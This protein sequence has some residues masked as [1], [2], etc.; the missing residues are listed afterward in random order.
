MLLAGYDVLHKN[1]LARDQ[2]YPFP[3]A[4]H[5]KSWQQLNSQLKRTLVAEAQKHH[6]CRWPSIPAAKYMDFT[7]KG[8]RRGFEELYFQRRHMLAI[9]V[10]GECIEHQGR[11]LDDII[12]GV[13]LICEETSWILPAHNANIE[14]P[15]RDH[16]DI[17][18]FAAETG[19]LLS[20]VFYLLGDELDQRSPMVRQRMSKEII[21]RVIDPF[22][23]TNDFHWLGFNLGP[24]SSLHNWTT[25]I[26]SNIITAL[27]LV[28]EDA[29]KRLSGIEKIVRSIDIFLE[30][31]HTDGGCDEG[32]DYWNRAGGSLF[33]LLEQLYLATQSQFTV[34]DQP[35]IGRIGAYIYRVNIAGDYFVNFADA[36]AK[37]TING[38]TAYLYG[39]R[40]KDKRL[41]SLGALVHQRLGITGMI[42]A[43]ILSLF[44][45]LVCIFNHDEITAYIP[46]FPYE[47]DVWLH[48][49]Q[50]VAAREQPNST[51][52]L[53]FA[54]KGGHNDESHNHN[55]VG[56]FILFYNGEPVFIDVGVETYTAKTF[57][58][59]RYCIWTMQSA[60]HNLPLIGKYQQQAGRRYT[61]SQVEYSSKADYVRFA[62][63]IA[64][65][66]SQAAGIIIWKRSY[67]LNRADSYFEITDEFK[68]RAPETVAVVFISSE[69]MQKTKSGQII[70]ARK[71]NSVKLSYDS[72]V[73]TFQSEKIDICDQ[74]LSPVWGKT[75]YRNLLLTKHVVNQEKWIFKIDKT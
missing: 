56:S 41:A 6:C 23:A 13:W 55:D 1:I 26:N 32:P 49:T 29:A 54:A 33:D 62:M 2:F 19:A 5:R 61:A 59:D 65:A 21:S 51:A 7:R 25:W 72:N 50:I 36:S 67:L 45:V 30:R 15:D 24:D 71:H 60:Y 58:K 57:G 34:Y 69:E 39:K 12:N 37:P 8:I 4:A 18:L 35:L 14:L 38:P 63:N 11:F 9:L 73:F 17:D 28:E 43:E 10:I 20:W 52:G 22:L 66:Y 42:K 68:L 75:I 53:Y 44:R 48:E 47:Q 64:Q 40:I 46:K 3:K 27:L 16:L 74:R 70:L 31:Y